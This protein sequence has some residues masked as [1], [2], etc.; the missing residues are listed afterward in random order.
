MGFK[1]SNCIA[2]IGINVP[3]A[4]FVNANAAPNV[5]VTDIPTN[6]TITSVNSTNWNS[7]PCTIS[8]LAIGA[9][10][11]ITVQATAP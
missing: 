9:T 7:L 5:I 8:T 6:L 3:L 2:V 4:C 11:V 10:E 1:L